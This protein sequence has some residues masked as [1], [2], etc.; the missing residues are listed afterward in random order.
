MIVGSA[1]ADALKPTAIKQT[2]VRMR[3]QEPFIG[4]SLDEIPG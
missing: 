3:A 4:G 2:I 1:A